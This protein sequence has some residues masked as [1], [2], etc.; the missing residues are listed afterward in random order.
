MDQTHAVPLHLKC[1]DTSLL[2]EHR[3]LGN[4]KQVKNQETPNS[5]EKTLGKACNYPG[6]K[7][8]LTKPT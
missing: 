6:L 7:M 2:L 1:W 5:A 3:V 4:Q 8:V